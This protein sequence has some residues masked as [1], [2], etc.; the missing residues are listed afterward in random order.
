MAHA[1]D[2]PSAPYV[3][4]VEDDTALSGALQFS[5]ELE[6]FLVDRC[7]S[8]EALLALELPTRRA[9]LVIDQWLPGITG[10]DALVELRRRGVRL[11]A[12][13]ITTHPEDEL[14]QA[15]FRAHASVVEKPLLGDS[16]SSEIK[17]LLADRRNP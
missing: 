17:G 11:P 13:I 16:L 1:S 10:L 12:V 5:L 7:G 15:A 6:G 2:P 3:V 9:C 8:G 14:R 4:I